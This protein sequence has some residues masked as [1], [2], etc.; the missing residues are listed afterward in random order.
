[1]K[2]GFY[3]LIF[4]VASFSTNLFAQPNNS[5]QLT[6]FVTVIKPIS[7]SRSAD[8]N[9]GKITITG[10]GT[11]VVSTVGTRTQTGGITLLNGGSEAPGLFNI[12]GQAAA[13]Y[14]VTIPTSVQLKKSGSAT[15]TI[16]ADTFTHN[17]IA[18]SGNTDQLKIGATIRLAGSETVGAYVSD[19]FAV[20]VS[21]N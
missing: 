13:T 11:V 5:A 12:T 8:L 9:F 20:T 2:K 15:E 14:A 10:A 18:L 21:Y 19:L 1:M 7:I 4:T 3:I 6:A 17:A 16:T